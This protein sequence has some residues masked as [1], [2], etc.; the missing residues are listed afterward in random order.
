MQHAVC[1]H[2]YRSFTLT[3]V[4]DAHTAHCDVLRTL[5]LQQVCSHA[6]KPRMPCPIHMQVAAGTYI[7]CL[8]INLGPLGCNVQQGLSLILDPK[9]FPYGLAAARATVTSNDFAPGASRAGVVRPLLARGGMLLTIVCMP[10]TICMPCTHM[11]ECVS[12]PSFLSS[13]WR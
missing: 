3:Q 1:L 4:I 2:A 10:C 12:F 9:S 7:P 6:H 11:C 13:S 8:V 5:A